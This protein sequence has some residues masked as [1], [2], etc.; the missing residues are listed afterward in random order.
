M[1]NYRSPQEKKLL[2]Y[3]KDCRNRGGGHCSHSRYAIAAHKARDHRAYRRQI[4]QIL[5]GNEIQDANLLEAVD[6]EVKTVPKSD[7]RKY[8]DTPLG[9]VLKRRLE[10]RRYREIKKTFENKLNEFKAYIQQGR[11]AAVKNVKPALVIV[12]MFSILQ[13]EQFNA[14]RIK[15]DELITFARKKQFHIIDLP[16]EFKIDSNYA[17]LEIR[18]ENIKTYIEG[19]PCNKIFEE[20]VEMK[21]EIEIIEKHIPFF[22][23]DL[24]NLLKKL[25]PTYLV[26][27]GVNTN[28]CIRT[29]A[30][31]AYQRNYRV[32]IISDCVASPDVRNPDVTLNS[33]SNR[34]AKVVSLARFEEDISGAI[35]V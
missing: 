17:F 5:A 14:Q 30:V 35:S 28:A 16:H 11:W 9:E 22:H 18:S 12:D 2:S 13:G 8:P 10:W 21:G 33:L 1:K 6:V 3:K 20:L 34:I 27:A 26:L 23:T 7:W 24:N 4:N 25:N 29:A 32:Q 31:D 15:L 19:T